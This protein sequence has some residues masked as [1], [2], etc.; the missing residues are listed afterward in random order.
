MWDKE[1]I[2]ALLD[3][4]DDAVTRA[5]SAIYAL[6]TADEKATEH[7]SHSNSVGFSAFDAKF[8]SDLATKVNRG[9]SLSPKQIAIARNKMKRYHRQLCD[10]ANARDAAKA[11]EVGIESAAGVLAIP[12]GECDC[13]NYDGE[14]KCP[15]CQ[16]KDGVHQDIAWG[17]AFGYQ[18][19]KFERRCIS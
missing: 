7:T 11:V 4:R 9:Y 15:S 2:H 12:V 6:Q 18:E 19:A 1:K 14:M 13:E 17:N 5:L 16:V 3:K 10:I 8:C